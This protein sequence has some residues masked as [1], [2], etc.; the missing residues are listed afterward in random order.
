MKLFSRG[1]LF[2]FWAGMILSLSGAVDEKVRSPAPLPSGSEILNRYAKAVGGKEAFRK[3]QSQHAV[4]T[5]DMRAQKMTGKLEVFAARPNK[6]VMKVTIP[7][8]GDLVS[9]FNGEVGWMTTALTGPM[10]LEGA[11]L[12]EVRTQA[13]FDHALHDPADYKVIEVLGAEEFNGE[14]CYKVKLVHRSG[15]VSTEYFSKKS[16]LQLGFIATQQTPLGPV[17]GTTIVSDYRNFGDLYMPA[18]MAQK[19]SG[20]ETVM[21]IKEMEF[22]QVDPSVFDVPTEV[23][24]LLQQKSQPAVENEKAAE[25]VSKSQKN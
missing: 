8:I 3:H 18:Q 4:G 22:D 17:S 9:G 24:T 19:A 15:F 7:G 20:I 14:N 2:G 21:T 23:K 13:D 11:M 5:V 12:D 1:A 25:K 16:G 10:L 6:L